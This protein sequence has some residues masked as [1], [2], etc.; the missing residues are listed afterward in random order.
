MITRASATL[1]IHS[2]SRHKVAQ[3]AVEALHVSVLPGAGWL[4]GERFYLSLDQPG[5]QGASHELAAVVAAEMAGHPALGNQLFHD[6]DEVC[7]RELAGD[8]EG[9]AL[10]GVFI[11]DL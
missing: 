3:R 11:K 10:A 9:Q 7:C 4:D 5:L 2:R 1:S 6:R 8:V